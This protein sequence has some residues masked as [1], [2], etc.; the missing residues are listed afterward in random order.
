[1]SHNGD[2]GKNFFLLPLSFEQNK[3]DALTTRCLITA[4]CVYHVKM[5]DKGMRSLEAR[6]LLVRKVASLCGC[7]RDMRVHCNSIDE[8]CRAYN[9]QERPRKHAL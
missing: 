5:E 4:A 9:R 6:A 7:L 2:R 8:C 1:M 3:M